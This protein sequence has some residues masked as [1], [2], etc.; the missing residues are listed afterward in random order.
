MFN[1]EKTTCKIRSGRGTDT[2]LLY[3]LSCLQQQLAVMSVATVFLLL[4][5]SSWNLSLRLHTGSPT[6]LNLY[7]FTLFCLIYCY[8]P[9]RSEPE[10]HPLN[11]Q[12]FINTHLRIE[13]KHLICVLLSYLGAIN[14]SSTKKQYHVNGV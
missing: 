13:P 1:D 7:L 6:L 3:H 10:L 12:Q 9:L 5:F 11:I 14:T 4:F 8:A 2:H